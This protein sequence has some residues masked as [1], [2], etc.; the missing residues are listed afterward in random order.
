[1]WKEN[2]TPTKKGSAPGQTPNPK[3]GPVPK[4]GGPQAQKW[5]NP[6]GERKMPG[7]APWPG[8]MGPPKC[9]KPRGALVGGMPEC[10]EK[11]PCWENGNPKIGWTPKNWGERPPWGGENF[12]GGKNPQMGGKM[13]PQKRKG[14][15]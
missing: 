2:V 5:K 14:F 10:A 1:L 8:K 3:K 15:A 7:G 4:R 13:G 12:C 6:P 9:N 11:I